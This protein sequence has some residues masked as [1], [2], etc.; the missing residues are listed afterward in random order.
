MTLIHCDWASI[1]ECLS[2]Y[3]FDVNLFLLSPQIWIV[4]RNSKW[5]SIRVCFWRKQDNHRCWYWTGCITRCAKF[6]HLYSYKHLK[7]VINVNWVRNKYQ[8]HARL[9]QQV[10]YDH[11]SG[12][13]VV[14]CAILSIKKIAATI[15]TTK[16]MLCKILLKVLLS[17]S[18]QNDSPL[19]C[20]WLNQKW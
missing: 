10:D 7:L 15:T 5:H 6:T 8:S 9:K 12:S 16:K 14:R 18:S 3:W 17:L 4:C 13:S 11:C 20:M 1:T 2:L 19:R